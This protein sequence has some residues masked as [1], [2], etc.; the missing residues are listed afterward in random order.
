MSVPSSSRTVLARTLSGVALVRRA[1]RG[2]AAAAWLCFA[3]SAWPAAA[4]DAAASIADTARSDRLELEDIFGADR[5]RRIDA[6]GALPRVEWL[7]DESYL[8]EERRPGADEGRP[9]DRPRAPLRVDAK[10]GRA[11]PFYDVDRLV[12]ALLAL[13]GFDERAAREAAGSELHYDEAHTAAV[14]AYAGDLFHWRLGSEEVRRLTFDPA[15]EVGH[16]LSPDGRMVSFVRGNDLH[17]IEL[18]SG[19]ERALTA[20]GGDE[21]LHGR[22]DWVYQEEVYGRGN[23]KGYWWSPDSTRIAFLRLDESPVREFT[24]VDH[25]PVELDLEVT[26]YPKAGSP[27][28]KVSLGV[29]AAA[30]GEPIWVDTGKYEPIEHLIVRVGWTPWCGRPE[31]PDPPEVVY[32]VQDREQT[33]LD[34]DLADASTGESRT[35]FRETTPAFVSVLGE[36]EWLSDGSFLWLSERTGFQHVYRYDREGKLLGAVTAGEWEVRD[37]HGVAGDADGEGSVYFAATA[38]SPIA[39]HLY[40]V[41]L[42]GGEPERLSRAE[43]SH[44]AAWSP[45]FRYFVDT[46]SDVRTPPQM[47]LHERSGAEVRVVADNPVEKLERFRLGAVERVQV[48]TRDGF[49][50]EAMLIKPPDF[51]P[52]RRYPVLQYN[53]GGPHAPVVSDAW[54]G[55]RYLWHQFLAQRGYVIWLCDNRSASGKGIRPTWEAYGRMGAVEL[56]DIEDGVEWLRRQPW[57][58]PERIGIWGWSYG[59]FMAAYA[60]T[61]SQSFAIGIAGAPVTDWRLYDTIYTERYMKMPQNNPDGYRETSVI[62]AAAALSGKLLLLHG[63]I[64]DNVHL[65][66]TLKLA[67]ELQ[68]AGKEFELMLY[69]KSRHGVRD[70]AL[71]LHLYRTMT[72][73]VLENL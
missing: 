35:L 39:P 54:S 62:E 42:S 66:N 60:L 18:A 15:P 25:I 12:A 59:G 50:M 26:N 72:R 37:L 61:H 36:P 1:A 29:I 6:T 58:D 53:Y 73:F 24:V 13:A 56:R 38:H 65:Q 70:R 9:D 44:D 55:P 28:P 63:T 16:E 20:G 51:D 68:K 2:S 21:L 64:D 69:P 11:A 8:L 67:Y 7:D 10:S 45:G 43:G 14:F 22:L 41:A 3:W 33:W 4:Q 46:W 52:G 23:F 71:E 40:R 5:D 17:L 57:V 32:Q 47:R 31:C 27:N 48:P 30:G 19:R 34:L 49:V